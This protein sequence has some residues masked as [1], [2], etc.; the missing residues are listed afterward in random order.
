MPP[1]EAQAKHDR[2]TSPPLAVVPV[3]EGCA[4]LPVT[5]AVDTSTWP[6]WL[7]PASRNPGADGVAEAKV[8]VTVSA[9]VSGLVTGQL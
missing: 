9:V 3:T 4:E 1:V 8:I 2:T 7:A 6:R 5:S